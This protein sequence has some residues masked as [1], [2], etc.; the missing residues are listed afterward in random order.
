MKPTLRYRFW[1]WAYLLSKDKVKDSRSEFFYTDL[2]C[3][4]CE[5]WESVASVTRDSEYLHDPK[6]PDRNVTYVCGLCGKSSLWCFETPVP[7][8]IETTPSKS[9]RIAAELWV[10]RNSADEYESY[11]SLRS[12]DKTLPHIPV[13]ENF[14]EDILERVL[15]KLN[16]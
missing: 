13:P 11:L 1:K 5:T 7:T 9:S 15:D 12:G 16:A 10:W 3:P 6:D 2:R 8:L 14:P 4:H